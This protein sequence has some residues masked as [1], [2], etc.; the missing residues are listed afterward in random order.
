METP[1]G[2][3]RGRCG[4]RLSLAMAALAGL[5]ALVMLAFPLFGESAG[6]RIVPEG[7]PM[8]PSVAGLALVLVAVLVASL[9]RSDS[10]FVERCR[11]GAAAVVLAVVAVI[12]AGRWWRGDWSCDG[13]M[14]PLSGLILLTS[15]MALLCV[16]PYRGRRQCRRGCGLGA[17]LLGICLTT[18]PLLACAA[19]T[20][21]VAGCSI[22]G[23]PIPTAGVLLCLNLALL[24][25]AGNESWLCRLVS[26]TAER[27]EMPLRWRDRVLLVAAGALLLVVVGLSVAYMRVRMRAQ[28]AMVVAELRAVLGLKLA[29]VSA[30]RRERLGD[31]EVLSQTPELADLIGRLQA[32]TSDPAVRR[33]V[34]QWL[35][36]CV[37]SYSYRRIAILDGERQPLAVVSTVADDA[38][39]D[40]GAIPLPAPPFSGIVELDP[41]LDA[42]GELR[43]DFLAVVPGGTDRRPAGMILIQ[44]EPEKTLLPLVRKWPGSHA[45]AEN[46]LWWRRD[47]QFVCLSGAGEASAGAVDVHGPL[48]L[49]RSFDQRE[50]DSADMVIE[51][52][53]WRGVPVIGIGQWVPA[54]SWL[55][56]A[57][58]DHRELD[59]ILQG[60]ARWISVA[61][62]AFLL[63]AG[64]GML[65]VW[66]RRNQL[67]ESRRLKAELEQRR[68]ATRLGLV[69]RY[70]NDA[71]LILDDALRIVEIN[72]RATEL[73]GLSRAELLRCTFSDFAPAD[74]RPMLDR[75][76]A[77]ARATGRTLFDTVH[78]ARGGRV[79]SVECSVSR[80]ELENHAHLLVVVRDISDR[81]RLTEELRRS[82]ERYRLIAENTIDMIW[83]ADIATGRFTYVSPAARRVR[84]IAPEELLGRPMTAALTPEAQ[85]RVATDFPARVAAFNAGNPNARH[86][87]DELE[88]VR[89]D[90]AVRQIEVSTSLMPDANGRAVTLLGVTRDITERKRADRALRES[91]ERYRLI[92]ENTSDAIWLF[93]LNCRRFTYVSPAAERLFGYPLREQCAAGLTDFLSPASAAEAERSL[94]S[95]TRALAQGD[96]GARHR[97]SR[98]EFLH[99]DGR[100]IVCEVVTSLLCDSGGRPAQLL[101]VTRDISERVRAEALL[102][103][104]EARF[105]VIAEAT[106]D[107][108]WLY[109][110]AADRYRYVSPAVRGLLGVTPEQTYDRRLVDFLTPESQAA[111]S[112]RIAQQ[113]AVFAAGD[114]GERTRIYEVEFIHADGGLV[115]AEVSVSVLTDESGRGIGLAGMTRDISERKRME[116]ALRESEHMLTAV[117]E[118]ASLGIAFIG[119]DDRFRRVNGSLCRMFGRT[120]EELRRLDP[121]ELSPAEDLAH[122]AELLDEVRAGTR[123]SFQL[124]KRYRRQDG[125][126]FWGQL[127]LSAVRDAAGGLDGLVMVVSDITAR[128][129]ADEAMEQFSL[130]LERRVTARTAELEARTREVEGL[131]DSIPDV[132]L[133][134]GGDGSIVFGHLPEA[135]A[136]PAYLGAAA[137]GGAWRDDPLVREILGTMPPLA[138]GGGET[139]VREFDGSAGDGSC[140]VEA[141][142]TPLGTEQVLILL[143]DITARRRVE[144]EVLANLERERQLSEMKSQFL[145]VASHEFRTPLAAAVGTLEL[146]ENH[147]ERLVPEKRTELLARM[148]R[149]LGRLTSIMNDVL[150]IS[151]A[152]AGRV[153]AKHLPL[154][155]GRFVQDVLHE[156]EDADRGQHRFLFE[157]SGGP[158]VV[159][160]DSNLLHHI[161]TN[162]LGNAVRYSPAGTT[163][164]LELRHSERAFVL[165]VADEG[166]G[167]PEAERK[168]IFEPFVR[169]SNVGQIGGT[170]LGLNI[171]KRYAELLGGVV[172]LLPA[173]TGATFQVSVPRENTAPAEQ[174][175][176]Q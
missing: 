102:R 46:L 55:L 173:S 160:T 82:E 176:H 137:A 54:S 83:L 43:I 76:I 5:Q 89:S 123:T 168:R 90:G 84:G 99:R 27:A 174:E 41:Y 141:R 106:S 75:D 105:R 77:K 124:E 97:T 63:M 38:R 9:L 150:T 156:I 25:S 16:F 114:A 12:L 151:R 88:L 29:Q 78:R 70:A 81:V 40:L 17:V 60:E 61:V 116:A 122:L 30:W 132:V 103:E 95:R 138:R 73:Y 39:L 159:A 94:Q 140:S 157:Q 22:L 93:D 14:V 64:S 26:G 11:M 104:S 68:L 59:R 98:Y 134:C 128:R 113:L 35:Q 139:V 62:A 145:S 53:D 66:S 44:T 96:S 74:A 112:A 18:I 131:L 72:D 107:V 109:D 154:G 85:L 47:G 23:I 135:E 19:G 21:L 57:K 161:L 8:A 65:V 80:V 24:A 166:I 4:R 3:E 31:T 51:A 163:V 146:L 108:I 136:V 7:T 152:D 67:E 126:E 1:A 56:I 118:N 49:V 52:A 79:V 87:T 37:E 92:A 148:H 86:A 153:A 171:V 36:C 34:E 133:L 149:S 28:R 58:L 169:G 111:V 164:R 42:A 172:E 115:Q 130:E 10:R 127:G 117:F 110:L 143:R 170:G 147:G 20:P 120:E 91:E 33:R 69:M 167:V 119:A 165:T 13:R 175:P 125:S 121:R 101:G 100:V 162:L 2:A 50:L 158:D 71:I 144:A 129:R 32:P 142:A 48:S 15:A 6:R 45:T 155:L